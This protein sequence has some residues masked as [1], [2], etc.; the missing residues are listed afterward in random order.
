MNNRTSPSAP[1]IVVVLLA[2]ALPSARSADLQVRTDSGILEGMRGARLGLRVFEGI[3][4]AAPP[5]G[6]LR[7]REPR[8]VAPWDGVRKAVEFGP[9]PMQ[10]AIYSDMIFRDK[11]PSEDCLYLNVWTPAASARDQLPVMVWIYGGGLQAGSASEPRQD[12]GD[13]TRKG[14]VVVSMNYRLGVFGFMAHPELSRESGHGSGNYGLM[15][16]IAAL[17]WVRRNIAAF[18]GDPGNVTIFGESAGSLVGVRASWPRRLPRD[19][20]RRRW[21]ERGD[22]GRRAQEGSGDHS[23]ADARR[24]G[25]SPSP[26]RQGAGRLAGSRRLPAGRAPSRR[27]WPTGQPGHGHRRRRVRAAHGTRTQSTGRGPRATSRSWRAGTPT[28]SGCGAPSGASADREE[29]RGRRGL[30]V[31]GR[32]GRRAQP[33]PCGHRRAGRPVRG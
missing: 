26:P 17:Q 14:V 18:G 29:L 2:L 3:P 10:G 33:L 9:R 1:V 28:S 13:L 19:S 11:G 23:L 5:V 24:R 32:G 30:A 6:D 21:G 20:S 7:W 4:F 25:G 12:G 8:P 31:R 27:R 22:P 15:D 16:Q